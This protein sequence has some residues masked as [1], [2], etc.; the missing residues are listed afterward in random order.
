MTDDLDRW[1]E[2]EAEDYHRQRHREAMLGRLG[3]IKSFADIYANNAFVNKTTKEVT[4]KIAE[5]LQKVIDTV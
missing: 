3:L 4:T 5:E 1:A 2:A